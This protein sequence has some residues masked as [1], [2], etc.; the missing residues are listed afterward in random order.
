MEEQRQHGSGDKNKIITCKYKLYT[1]TFEKIEVRYT[2]PVCVFQNMNF[3]S[4][5]SLAFA[6]F[7]VDGAVAGFSI[8]SASSLAYASA[9]CF[10]CFTK[11]LDC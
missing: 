2:E 10:A 7:F 9:S 1:N 11:I 4:A 8:Q 5:S 3:A 6:S